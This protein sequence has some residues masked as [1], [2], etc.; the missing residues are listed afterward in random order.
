MDLHSVT[1]RLDRR[2]NLLKDK[3]SEDI[4]MVPAMETNIHKLFFELEKTL[5]SEMRDWWDSALLKKYIDNKF[6]PRGLRFEKQPFFNDN[7]PLEQEWLGALDTCSFILMDILIRYRE[8][9]LCV[10]E[11]SIMDLQ[12]RIGSI[13][14]QSSVISKLDEATNQKLISF[15]KELIMR[16][17]KKFQRDKLDYQNGQVRSWQRKRSSRSTYNHPVGYKE[18]SLTCSHLSPKGGFKQKIGSYADIVRNPRYGKGSRSTVYGEKTAIKI[19]KNPMP[20]PPRYNNYSPNPNYIPL[21]RNFRPDK[22]EEVPKVGVD[23]VGGLGARPK[24][25]NPHRKHV[26]DHT[27]DDFLE[28]LPQM[29]KDKTF[30]LFKRPQKRRGAF[31]EERG[32]GE[33]S[34]AKMRCL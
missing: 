23:L 10:T 20:P 28:S 15:E 14:E 33:N 16:K 32:E 27:D 17:K 7:T 31:V 6:I 3:D 22:A 9:R 19:K 26:I 12:G 13:Q 25:I 1:N 11:K 5:K 2:I 30:P 34:P 18:G 24:K 21:G 29:E 8:S 4:E